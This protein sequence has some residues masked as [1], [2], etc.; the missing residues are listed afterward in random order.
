MDNV[1][2]KLQEEKRKA[3]KLFYSKFVNELKETYW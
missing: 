2:I 1:K 3:V